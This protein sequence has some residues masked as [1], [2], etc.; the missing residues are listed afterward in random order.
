MRQG[1]PGSGIPIER[2]QVNAYTIPT[3]TPEADGTLEWN[4]TTLVLV[5]AEAAGVSGTGYSYADVAT[6][7]L[8]EDTLVSE[9]LGRDAMAISDCW[10]A[11]VRRIRNLGRPGICSMAIAAEDNALL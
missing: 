3:R 8:I 7:K 10:Q 5:T 2:V 11:M 9:V 1:R 6:A 4:K